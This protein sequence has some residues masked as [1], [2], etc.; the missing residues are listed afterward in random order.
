MQKEHSGTSYFCIEEESRAFN[1]HD[2]NYYAVG[3]ECWE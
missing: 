1:L 3:R 2:S